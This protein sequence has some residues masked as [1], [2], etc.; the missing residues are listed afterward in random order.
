MNLSLEPARW[1]QV[2]QEHQE[3]RRQ[4]DAMM[5]IWQYKMEK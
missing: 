1:K 4:I 5:E 3:T 2:Q